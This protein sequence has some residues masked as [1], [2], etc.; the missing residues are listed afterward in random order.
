MV[1]F[2][3]DPQLRKVTQIPLNE[4]WLP[5]GSV[6]GPRIR[7][8]NRSEISELLRQ[9]GVEFVVANVGEQLQWISAQDCFDFWKNKVKAHLAESTSRIDLDAFPGAYC[10]TASQWEGEKGGTPIVL[11]ERHH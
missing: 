1:I 7:A 11:L 4:L 5:A 6:I 2:T 8:L 10:Y 3:M 9:N